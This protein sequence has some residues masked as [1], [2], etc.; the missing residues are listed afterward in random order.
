MERTKTS[1]PRIKSR[2]LALEIRCKAN[3]LPL[4]A[5]LY[6]IALA[7]QKAC[8]PRNSNSTLYVP[9]L[10][11]QMRELAASIDTLNA[12]ARQ[13]MRLA[14]TGV[15]PHVLLPPPP[16]GP[17]ADPD[18]PD[19]HSSGVES[20]IRTYV[21]FFYT[22]S[23]AER[24]EY[25]ETFGNPRARIGAERNL[26]LIPALMAELG[27]PKEEVSKGLF[28]HLYRMP[29]KVLYDSSKSALHVGN[30]LNNMAIRSVEYGTID[31][32]SK[33]MSRLDAR[34][35]AIEKGQVR[36]QEDERLKAEFIDRAI[37]F[38]KITD[39]NV[40]DVMAQRVGTESAIQARMQRMIRKATY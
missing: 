31:N 23:K 4:K 17:Q 3:I 21:D 24:K 19:A 30:L 39:I 20:S 32:F 1:R 29:F 12:H 37:G 26:L 11:A 10:T 35:K 15:P 28:W 34:I 14:P 5:M 16:L 33:S 2:G 40:I 8:K 13:P 38:S 18:D 7:R 9:R 22:I 36:P 6:A 27:Q 25:M